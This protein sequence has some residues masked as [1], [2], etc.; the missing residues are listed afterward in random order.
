MHG[1]KLYTWANKTSNKHKLHLL[2]VLFPND[3]AYSSPP[4]YSMQERKRESGVLC[5]VRCVGVLEY[6]SEAVRAEGREEGKTAAKS[7]LNQWHK[8]IATSVF[9]V[10]PTATRKTLQ[11]ICPIKSTLHYMTYVNIRFQFIFIIYTS[12]FSFSLKELQYSWWCVSTAS[13]NLA[14][15]QFGLNVHPYNNWFQQEQRHF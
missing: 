8:T 13:C 1:V 3:P 10:K 5:V 6:V 7:E 15:D 2:K 12:Y 11:N 4:L 9:T 14:I